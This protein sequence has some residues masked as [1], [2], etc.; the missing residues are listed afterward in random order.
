MPD[1]TYC[2]HC[3][4]PLELQDSFGRTRWGCPSC[5]YVQFDDPKVAVGVLVGD[6]REILLTLRNHEPQQG[7]WSFPAGF[8]DRGEDVELAAIREVQEETGLNI[9]IDELL[10]V[11]SKAGDPVIFIA[12]SGQVVDG[13]LCAGDEA[14]DAAFFPADDL[15]P[16]AF[17]HDIEIVG[18]WRKRRLVGTK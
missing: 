1:T 8:V 13:E 9:A 10:G 12:Y 5:G 3:A 7:R 11:F 15:P 14:D 4:S 6:G 17:P 2:Q 18:A 16:L